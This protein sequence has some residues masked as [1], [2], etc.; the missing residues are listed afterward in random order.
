MICRE[1]GATQ[2]EADLGE[3]IGKIMSP[4]ERLISSETTSVVDDACAS[5]DENYISSTVLS[6]VE[7]Y[8]I[9]F[10]GD[11]ISSM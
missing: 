2:N 10:N 5:D 9:S 6:D 8:K 7:L 3:G 11:C 4:A 1:T